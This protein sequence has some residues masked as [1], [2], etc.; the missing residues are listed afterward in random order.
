MLGG[1][2]GPSAPAT[3]QVDQSPSSDSRHVQN[4]RRGTR[5]KADL[6]SRSLEVFSKK[7]SCLVVPVG[8]WRQGESEELGCHPPGALLPP[9]ELLV[10][11]RGVEEDWSSP[12]PRSSP[13][14]PEASVE[15]APGSPLPICRPRR[16]PDPAGCAGGSQGRHLLRAHSHPQLDL[17]LSPASTRQA[18]WSGRTQRLHPVQAGPGSAAGRA[19]GPCGQGHGAG[20]AGGEL[21]VTRTQQ[22]GHV[23]VRVA[24]C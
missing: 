3:P 16:C 5:G 19:E 14:L 21:I 17:E 6:R 1:N 7:G 13:H 15:S 9:V 24:T 12:N 22:M 4:V 2:P 20:L 11:L 10:T 18:A 23:E 8:V